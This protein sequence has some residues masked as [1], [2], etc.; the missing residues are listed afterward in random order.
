MRDFLGNELTEGDFVVLLTPNYRGLA[1]GKVIKLTPKKVRVEYKNTWN[2]G[3]GGKTMECVV[4]AFSLI[5]LEGEQLTMKL[6][7]DF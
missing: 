5:R 7:K 1:L 2:Y 6:L 4:A 3:N